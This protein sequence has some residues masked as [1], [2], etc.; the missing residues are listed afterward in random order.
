M[1]EKIA[2]HLLCEVEMSRVE[3]DHFIK[4]KLPFVA[5]VV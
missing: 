1:L 4:W 3:Y 2:V 5:L